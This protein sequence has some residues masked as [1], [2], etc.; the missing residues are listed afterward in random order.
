MRTVVREKEKEQILKLTFELAHD[1]QDK[2]RESAVKLLN[3]LASDMGQELCEVYIV[4]EMRSLG[5][6]EFSN[7]RTAVVKNM[8][9]VSKNV[10][11]DCFSARIF[12]LYDSLTRDKEEKVRKACADVVADIAKVSPL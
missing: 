10:S 6:D 4:Q 9:N 3:E 7:V 11:L 8:L 5:M 12:P 2:L 1:E